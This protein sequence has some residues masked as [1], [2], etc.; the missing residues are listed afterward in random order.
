MNSL[1]IE[2]SIPA[3]FERQKQIIRHLR[4]WIEQIDEQGLIRGFAFDHYSGQGVAHADLRIR[5]DY[6]EVANPIIETELEKKVK[7]LIPEFSL[8]SSPWDSNEEILKGYEFGSRCAFLF[9][10]MVEKGRLPESFLSNCFPIDSTGVMMSIVPFNFQSHFYHGV[11][12]SLGVMKQPNELWLHLLAI[13]ESMHFHN[14][15]ELCEWI[16]RQPQSFFTLY[17]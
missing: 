3:N 10:Q 15:E 13:I 17:P 4:T 1:W 6:L 14:P 7:E 16:R 12:N 9:W 2:Y 8:N 11:M 5:F